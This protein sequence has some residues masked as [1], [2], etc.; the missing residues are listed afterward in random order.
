MASLENETEQ[1]LWDILM[2]TDEFKQFY[3][4]QKKE[5]VERVF[6]M[7]MSQI[8]IQYVNEEEIIQHKYF[9]QKMTDLCKSEMLQRN[10]RQQLVTAD[11]IKNSR[12]DDFNNSFAKIQQDY[13]SYNKEPQP[14]NVTFK[15]EVEEEPLDIEKAIQEKMNQRN[16][17]LQ[18]IPKED[19]AS[20]WLNLKNSESENDNAKQDNNTESNSIFSKLKQ[21]NKIDRTQTNQAQ[22]IASNSG[23]NLSN[24][25]N[26]NTIMLQQIKQKCDDNSNTIKEI[27]DMLKL[28]KV[29]FEVFVESTKKCD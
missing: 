24:A 6:H 19:D 21:L 7:T 25:S 15:D 28:L 26:T 5:Y 10:M 4:A 1:M 11:E 13:N 14:E 20:E 8:K 27:Y 23:Q 3:G 16:Y 2:E 22:V 12:L 18:N 17:E 29:E 9:I